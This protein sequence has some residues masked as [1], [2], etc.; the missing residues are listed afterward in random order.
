MG[1]TNKQSKRSIEWLTQVFNNQ[2]YKSKLG[3]ITNLEISLCH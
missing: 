2:L 3:G 1:Y